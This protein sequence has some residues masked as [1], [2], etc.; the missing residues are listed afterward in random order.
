MGAQGAGDE[1]V[2]NQR[3]LDSSARNNE[4]AMAQRHD[5][6]AEVNWLKITQSVIDL[7]S[8]NQIL[9]FRFIL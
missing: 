8:D 4:K 7:K 1:K 3:E 6:K 2:A 9:S 5:G